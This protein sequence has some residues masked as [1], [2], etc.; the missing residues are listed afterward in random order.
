MCWVSSTDDEVPTFNIDDATDYAAR[1]HMILEFTLITHILG[2]IGD[3]CMAI[4]IY[5][6]NVIFGYAALGIEI[7]YCVV[8]TVWLIWI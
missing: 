7:L 2:F 4:R 5:Y 1:F 6:K 3:A 8:Y